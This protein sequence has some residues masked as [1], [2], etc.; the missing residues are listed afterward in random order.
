MFNQVLKKLENTIN[1]GINNVK[2]IVNNLNENR[3]IFSIQ[4]KR[5]YLDNLIAEGGY[6]LIYKIQSVE[7]NRLYALKKITI[8]SPSHKKQIKRE[9]KIWKELSKFGN[10]VELKDFQW[11]EK[12]AYIIMELCEEGTLLDYVNNY[13]G[14]IPE[15]EALQIF[16]Q[17]LFGVNAMHSQKPPI[18]HRDLKIENILKKKRDYKLCDFGSASDEPFDPKISDE[19]VKEQ[20]FANFEKNSTLYYRAPEMCDRYGEHIVNEKVDIWALGCVLY[21]MVFKEQPFMNAQKL[22]IINGNYNFP[23]DEQKLYSEKFL[24]LIRALLTPNPEERPNILQVMEWTNYW[25]DTKNIPLSLEVQKIKEK[26]NASGG[27]KNKTHKKKLLSAEE[28][29]KIQ[30]KLKSKEKEKKKDNIDEINEMFGFGKSSNNNEEQINAQKQKLNDDLFAVFSSGANNQNQ[31]NN[32][33]IN[34]NNKKDD[35]LLDFYEVDESNM[36]KNNQINNNNQNNINNNFGGLEDIFSNKPKNDNNNNIINNEPKKEEN[37]IQNNNANM[38][39]LFGNNNNKSQNEQKKENNDLFDFG[40]QDNNNSNTNNNNNMDFKM[41][42]Q[43]FFS[44]FPSS[45]P[46][47]QE[48]I[49]KQNNDDDLFEAFNSPQS[50]KEKKEEKKEETNKN[51]NSLQDDLF[52]AFNQPNSNIKEENKEEKKDVNTNKI[53]LQDDLF[54]AFNQPNTNAKEVKKEEKNINKSEDFF[55]SFSQPNKPTKLQEQKEENKKETNN[56]LLEGMFSSPNPT[57]TEKPK[58]QKPE[59]KNNIDFDLFSFNPNSEQKVENKNETQNNLD[60]NFAFGI[61]NTTQE[62]ENGQ[63]IENGQIKTNETNKEIK[64]QNVTN[65]KGQDIFAFFQ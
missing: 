18:A 53:N 26:Q 15:M 2:M 21:T 11:G 23:R 41:N 19:F 59:I 54:S 63:T 50:S 51:K 35:D 9:I 4:Q 32:N 62:G 10:I 44:D 29:K 42:G 55:A 47:K 13:E 17:I 34:T 45:Q 46:S 48:E 8:Q 37:K 60:I 6:A 30:N 25:K 65:N 52:S 28:I 43:D 61:G 56:I 64:S 16:N 36:A 49:K 14:N 58:E 33:N 57:T 38:D 5:Y 7:D 22:E 12:H 40:A 27:I 20:N 39:L 24:D 1:A 31:I 3:P